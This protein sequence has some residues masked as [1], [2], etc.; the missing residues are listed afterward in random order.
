VAGNAVFNHPGGIAA[1]VAELR[2]IEARAV[3]NI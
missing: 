3:G 1:G 2:E